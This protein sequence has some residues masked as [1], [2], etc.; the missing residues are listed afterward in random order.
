MSDPSKL[1]HWT[2][3]LFWLP[4]EQKMSWGVALWMTQVLERTQL[5]AIE[6]QWS[7]QLEKWI[8]KPWRGIWEGPHHIHSG[9]FPSSR[10]KAR[11]IPVFE[12]Q[13][14]LWSRWDLTVSPL[15]TSFL[16]AC[17]CACVHINKQEVNGRCLSI[18]FHLFIILRQDL[19]LWTWCLLLGWLP[20]SPRGPPVSASP[21]RPS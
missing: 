18:A 9:Q 16:C 4:I 5:W 20:V 3:D 7:Q 21:M 13:E 17:M 11:A 14:Q 2:L 19:S 1:P 10:N 6:S 8:V 15:H 12:Y